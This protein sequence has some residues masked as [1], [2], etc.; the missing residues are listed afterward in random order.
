MKTDAE[1]RTAIAGLL[2]TGSGTDTKVIKRWKLFINDDDWMA[3]LHSVTKNNVVDGW[4]ITRVAVRSNFRA[5]Q[6][7]EKEYDYDLWYFRSFRDG[8]SADN[9]EYEVNALLDA[10]AEQFELSPQLGFDQ[11][12]DGVDRHSELQIRNIDTIDDSYHAVQC[13]LTVYLTKQPAYLP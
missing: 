13:R 7:W 4:Y 6:R 3:A 2:Q 11:T 8:T 1:I 5:T 12:Q 9:S 10:V